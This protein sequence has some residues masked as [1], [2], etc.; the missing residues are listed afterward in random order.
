MKKTI[1]LLMC[2]VS[3]ATTAP[4][5]GDNAV[6]NTPV[7]LSALKGEWELQQ[8][9][10]DGFT[11]RLRLDGT[12]GG[13]WFRSQETL[14]VSITYYVEGGELLL[15]HYYVPQVALN[16]GL[17]VKQLRFSYQ[18]DKTTLTLTKDGK[19]EVWKR[20]STAAAAKP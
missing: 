18:L 17:Y 15:E 3:I 1:L 4:V 11:Q 10:E 12:Q 14:P 5:R 6:V 9:A 13:Q 8:K 2:I 19:T 16:Y 7:L 20:K